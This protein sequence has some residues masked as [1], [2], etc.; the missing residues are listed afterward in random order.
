MNQDNRF[1]EFSNMKLEQWPLVFVYG[2]L[3]RGGALHGAMAEG[4]YIGEF[5]TTNNFRLYDLGMF[6]A[7]VQHDGGGVVYGEVYRVDYDTLT[8]LDVVEG[9]DR[10]TYERREIEVTDSEGAKLLAFIYLWRDAGF[11]SLRDWPPIKSGL[12]PCQP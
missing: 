11:F 5:H 4:Q 6:P 1:A 3:K 12:W 2:T 9:V 7:V 10:G 8:W